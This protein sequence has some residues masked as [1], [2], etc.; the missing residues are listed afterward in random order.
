M[1]KE[2]GKNRYRNISEEDKQKLERVS[3]KTIV[4]QKNNFI[5]ILHKRGV[6]KI[7]LW[8]FKKVSFNIGV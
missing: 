6:E 5:C 2:Y 3:K 7:D 1:K 8:W 4:R